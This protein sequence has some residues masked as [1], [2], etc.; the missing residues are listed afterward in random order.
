MRTEISRGLVCGVLLFAATAATASPAAAS[1]ETASACIVPQVATA[2]GPTTVDGVR[3]HEQW[4]AGP[5]GA[6]AVGAVADEVVATFGVDSKTD[7]FATL[8]RGLIGVTVDHLA[9][10]VVVVVE[11]AYR[12]VAALQARLTAATGAA[13][14]VEGASSVGVRVQAGCFAAADLL[15]A[16]STL[17]ARRWHGDAGRA[18][19]AFHLDPSDSAF[20]VSFDPRYPRAAEALQKSLGGLAA[21]TLDGASRAGRLDDGEPHYGG[22]GVR[23]GSGSSSSNTCTTGFVVIRNSD[24]RRGGVSA[25]HCFNNG[26][27]IYSGPQYWGQASGESGFPTWDQIGIFAASE[28]YA[29]KIHV[30]PCCPSVR[31]VTGRANPY[32]DLTVCH[33][34]MV[35][36]ATCGIRIVS[37]NGQFCDSDGCTTLLA[38]GTRSGDIIVRGGDSGGPV[39]TRPGSSTATIRGMVIAYASGGATM[40]AEQVSYIESHL[41]VRVATS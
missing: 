37:T 33:S 18:R 34:G 19:F 25:G 6:A 29:N 30:D 16:A 5:G 13:G 9:Q 31:T 35:S 12:G 24:G 14:L 8:R 36:R 20:H 22:A 32:I 27:Q 11:P 26:Q 10:A 41:G 28:T 23:V 40:Y 21:V 3:A 39:Y 38:V 17:Q 4:I 1:N 15:D 2:T 7:D